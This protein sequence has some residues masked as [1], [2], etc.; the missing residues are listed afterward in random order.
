[1]SNYQQLTYEQRCQIFVLKK[2]GYSQGAIA[3]SIGTRSST[4][5]R[6]QG[7]NA[8]ERGYRHEQ[9]QARSRAS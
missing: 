3:R 7:S 2:T 1:M 9:V 8:G 6:E 4:I 5:C